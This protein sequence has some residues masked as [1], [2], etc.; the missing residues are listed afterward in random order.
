MGPDQQGVGEMGDGSGVVG[1]IPNLLFVTVSPWVE[2]GGR[3]SDGRRRVMQYGQESQ[4]SK[5]R[6]SQTRNFML[7]FFAFCVNEE[8]V[9][10]ILVNNLS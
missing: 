6:L 2:V 8:L 1:F 5:V 7:V 10:F 3:L 4:E 9:P